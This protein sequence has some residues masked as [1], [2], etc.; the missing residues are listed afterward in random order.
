MK[1]IKK[2]RMGLHDASRQ[3]D[4][5]AMSFMQPLLNAGPF[6]P[7]SN[8][9]LRPI[10]MVCILSDVVINKPTSILEF[11]CGISSV[12]LGRLIRQTGLKC[13]VYSVEHDRQWMVNATAYLSNEQLTDVVQLIHA[14]LTSEGRMPGDEWYDTSSL[15]KAGI[16]EKTFDM[17]LIDGPP[18]WQMKKCRARYPAFPFVRS[19]LS[20]NG[21]VY[22]DDANRDG[23][24]MVIRQWQK[25]FQ[26]EFQWSRGNLAFYSPGQRYN[27]VLL[28]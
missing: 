22:L 8:G 24:K 25:D 26:I 3:D 21:V 28:K 23:E 1:T 27:P 12:L 6:L 2:N 5:Y 14:P 20:D 13:Q 18:A 10:D 9:T 19:L 16:T 11:G 15:V 4:I 17:V 7:F